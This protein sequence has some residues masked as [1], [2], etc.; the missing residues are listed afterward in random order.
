MNNVP[1]GRY[2]LP[3]WCQALL[4]ICHQL[5]VNN[6]F[7]KRLAFLMRKPVLMRKQSPIDVQVEGLKFRLFPKGNLS[8]KR[9][10]TMPGLLDGQERRFLASVLS[11]GA[12]VLDVG[13]NIGGYG[14]LL[15]WERKDLKLVAVEAHPELAARLQRHIEFNQLQSRCKCLQLAASPQSSVVKLYLDEVNQGCNSLL[16]GGEHPE[17][18]STSIDVKGLTISEILALADIDKL[19]LLKM[20]IEGFEFPV[21]ESFLNHAEEA[22]WPKYLQL[23][24]HKDAALSPAVSM[25]LS[26]GYIKV[27]QT[28]MNVI[29][30]KR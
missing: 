26:K 23:E 12:T 21:L 10:L 9:L 11:D 30:E 28:R 20:D 4:G 3:S 24:Q 18:V 16:K 15:A 14:L 19:E 13:A 7:A 25:A 22:A 8:D 27:L 6:W 29:L 17:R 1:F 5:P 2:R